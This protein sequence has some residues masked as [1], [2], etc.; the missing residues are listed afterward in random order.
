MLQYKKGI[1]KYSIH[2]KNIFMFDILADF[3]VGVLGFV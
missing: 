3:F 1:F 2:A